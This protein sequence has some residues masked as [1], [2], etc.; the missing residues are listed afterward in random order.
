MQR[1][2]PCVDRL[3]HHL[4]GY[5]NEPTDENHQKLESRIPEYV[6]E[7]LLF[8]RSHCSDWAEISGQPTE[9]TDSQA[10][11]TPIDAYKK[12]DTDY[13]YIRMDL[14]RAISDK[15]KSLPSEELKKMETTVDHIIVR[16]KHPC[17]EDV[18]AAHGMAL[19]MEYD[20]SR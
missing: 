13:D 12:L 5:I 16:I 6:M 19:M 11:K 14:S 2:A 20:L 15:Q 9:N 17:S 8:I 10:P 7:R 18:Q 3:K 1:Y 4:L